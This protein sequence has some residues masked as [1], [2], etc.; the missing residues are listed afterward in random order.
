MSSGGTTVAI[1]TTPTVGLSDVMPQQ[2][3]GLRSEPPMSLPRPI[4]LM[5]DAIA[6]ASPPLDP[7]AVTSGFHGLRVRPCSCEWVW[8]RRPK[9]GRFV[10]ANGIAPAARMRSTV[11]ASIGATASARAST[12]CVVGV[13]ATSMFSFTLHGTPCSR[14]EVVAVG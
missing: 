2:C 12:P 13:P 9:S 6:A 3:A 5:P 7:P 14:P 10:R 11:G 1:G 4:G 8:T